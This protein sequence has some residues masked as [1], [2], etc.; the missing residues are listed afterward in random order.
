VDLAPR[1]IE[2]AKAK[3]AERHS[4]AEFKVADATDLQS[5]GRSFDLALDCGL[6]HVLSDHERTS[7]VR[8]LRSA[9]RPGGRYFMLCF[10]DH[11]PDW[12]GPR[13]V[14][15]QEI[16][17]SFSRGWRVESI[18]PSKLEAFAGGAGAE[19]WFCR[20]LKDG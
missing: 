15:K 19:G 18:R 8:S 14:T 9:I 3:A 2:K 1:A 10:S 16:L 20:I 7:Y 17:D 5:L 13:R 6:F 11:E 12:G 4:R